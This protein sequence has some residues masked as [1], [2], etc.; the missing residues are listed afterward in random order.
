MTSNFSSKRNAGGHSNRQTPSAGGAASGTCQPVFKCLLAK[1]ESLLQRNGRHSK[2]KH[3]GGQSLIVPKEKVRK[4]DMAVDQALKLSVTAWI[5][6][7]EEK[8]E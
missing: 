5:K 6:A 2:R 3:S 1:V 4:V 8:R 7:N